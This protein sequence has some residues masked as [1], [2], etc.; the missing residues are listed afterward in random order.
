M[1]KLGAKTL[2][3]LPC[4]CLGRC[5]NGNKRTTMFLKNGDR[6]CRHGRVWRIMWVEISGKSRTR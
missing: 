3:N 5:G 4:G 1:R 6:V 2:P